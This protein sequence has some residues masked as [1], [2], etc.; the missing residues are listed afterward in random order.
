MDVT[1]ANKPMWLVDERKGFNE[2]FRAWKH[3]G[4]EGREELARVFLEDAIELNLE[5]GRE[6]WH[7]AKQGS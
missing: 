6:G 3:R 5:G 2:C 7:A 1:R 4:S